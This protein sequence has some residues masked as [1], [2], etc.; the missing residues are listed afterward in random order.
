[1]SEVSDVSDVSDVWNDRAVSRYL[2][3]V[4]HAMADALNESMVR[5]WE[6]E[7]R[8]VK[9]DTRR[10]LRVVAE[11]LGDGGR[12]AGDEDARRLGAITERLYGI[13]DETGKDYFSRQLKYWTDRL[14]VVAIR[15]DV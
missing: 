4:S 7:T 12:V 15:G 2:A 1:M 11:H 6:P 10:Q 8:G 3:A 14:G 13:L 9:T 5:A